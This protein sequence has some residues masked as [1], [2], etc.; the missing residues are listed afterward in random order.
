MILAASKKLLLLNYALLCLNE[1]T[2]RHKK[3]AVA[4]I[5]GVVPVPMALTEFT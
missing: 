5:A 2:N 4:L 1:I 3:F